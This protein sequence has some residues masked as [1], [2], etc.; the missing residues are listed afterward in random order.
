MRILFPTIFS[1]SGYFSGSFDGDG[2]RLS[3]IPTSSIVNFND[4][5]SRLTFP[6]IGKAVITGSLI[7]KKIDTGS[8]DFFIIKSG[9]FDSMKVNNKGV[10]S[11]GSFSSKPDPV[12]GGIIYSES[13]Y[14]IG[15]D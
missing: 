11:L 5:I 8:F 2:S 10:I 1:G 7:V 6:Y 14:W 9:S 4:E 15:L 13:N 12:S 3:N